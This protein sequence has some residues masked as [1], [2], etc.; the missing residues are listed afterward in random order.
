[1][2]VYLQYPWR[3]PDSSYYKYLIENPPQEVNFINALKQHGAITNKKKFWLLTRLKVNIRKWTNLLNLPIVNSWL[4]KTDEEFDIIHCAHCLS[5]N[6]NKPWVADM[7]SVWSMWVSGM[8]TKIG[9][10]K[11]KKILLQ[12]NCKKIMPW[13]EHTKREILKIFPEIGDKIEMVYP[14]VPIER[15]NKKYFN[16]NLTITFVGRDFRLKGGKI[17]LETMKKIKERNPSSKMIFVSSLP[18]GIKD[19]YPQI[20]MYNLLSTEKIAKIFSK[21]DLF[22][23][24]SLMDTFGFSILEAMSYGVPV[25]A[26][27]TQLTPSIREIVS[28]GI[29]GKVFSTECTI[30]NQSPEKVEKT[31]KLLAEEIIKLIS[32]KPLLIKMS[33]NC[34]NEIKYGKFSIVERNKKLKRIYENA[35]K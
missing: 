29:A 34:I 5:K 19:K 3:F 1:M 24:T 25:I 6:K 7:E 26:L 35:L 16:K 22:L 11:V 23:Y 32:N 18:D 9:R 31:A 4:T 13:T 17:A 10:E 14:A 20:E 21:T 33:N 2:K 8:N 12:K 30:D 27:E 15:K 28:E